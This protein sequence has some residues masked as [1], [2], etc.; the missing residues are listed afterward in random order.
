MKLDDLKNGSYDKTFFVFEQIRDSNSKPGN[1]KLWRISGRF[2][3]TENRETAVLLRNKKG[4]DEKIDILEVPLAFLKSEGL[5][6][7]WVV[8][9][10]YEENKEDSI[11]S[12]SSKEDI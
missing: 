5:S 4:A 3:A 2:V 1:H 10:K 11:S 9:T 8:R 7:F 12:E 6:K